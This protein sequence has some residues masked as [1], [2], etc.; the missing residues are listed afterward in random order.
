MRGHGNR[1]GMPTDEYSTTEPA[2]GGPQIA[3]LAPEP[4]KRTFPSRTR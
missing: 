1:E 4:L 2:D 3:A